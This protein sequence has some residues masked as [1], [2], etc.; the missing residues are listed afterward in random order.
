MTSANA[1]EGTPQT[2]EISLVEALWRYRLMSL[3]IVL[4]CVL[5]SVAATQILFN[6]VTA[7]ASFA[8]T[9]P[10]NNNNALRMGIVSGPGFAT[11][12]S[13]RAAFARSAPVLTR[14]AQIVASKRGP[15]LSLEG[16]R[17][18]VQTATK[19]DGGV[20]IVTASG[21][22][23]ATA[24]VIANA[25]LQSYVDLTLSTNTEKLSS[26]LKGIQ[27]A[28]KKI[29]DDLEVTSKSSP[30]Y[31]SMVANVAKLQVQESG[32][33]TAQANANDGVQFTD[34]ADPSAAAPSKLPRN[35]AIGLV[36]GLLIACVTSFL[37]ASAPRPI[38]TPRTAE[39]ML[40]GLKAGRRRK[41]S[42]AEKAAERSQTVWPSEDVLG[43]GYPKDYPAEPVERPVEGPAKPAAAARKRRPSSRTSTEAAPPS[44]DDADTRFD[45]PPWP[46]ADEPKTEERGNG[47]GRT[48]KRSSGDKGAPVDKPEAGPAE[49]NGK[50]DTEQTEPNGKF[51]VGPAER[52]GKPGFISYDFD[53]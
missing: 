22:N 17:A 44:T 5:A 3:I 53:R 26:Q 9:D 15:K 33:L 38:R 11:Y 42:S 13:Q 16:M 28:L 29:S 34:K 46:V 6:K 52:N 7:T 51:E 21:A 35:A 32:L 30:A 19:P 10:T 4:G 41:P 2:G 27:T 40:S 12:T 50:S 25:V 37:R 36:L 43:P 47:S 23:M 31:K 8:V 49:L 24:A 14:A 20:V 45:L 39:P 1:A 18:S 48:R